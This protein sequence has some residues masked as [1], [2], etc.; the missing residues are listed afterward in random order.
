MGNQLG[1]RLAPNTW[2]DATHEA[3]QRGAEVARVALGGLARQD[4]TVV[5]VAAA[6][7]VPLIEVI[8]IS[9]EEEAGVADATAAVAS[10]TISDLLLAS[11]TPL[12]PP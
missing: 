7:P 2:L 3:I 8:P 11:A 4:A 5:E 1:P 10:P 9:S 12:M 6:P